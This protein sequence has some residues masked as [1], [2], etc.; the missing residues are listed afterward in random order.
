M[1]FVQ[2][3]YFSKTHGIK[4]QL[5]LRLE[6]N[7]F[8]D[9]AKALLVETATGKAPFFISELKE[10]KVGL[11]IALEDVETI[12]KAKTLLGKKVFIDEKLLA[13]EEE[14]PNLLGFELIDKTHGSLGNIIE[15]SD[16]G[17]QVLVTVHLRNK[18]VILPLVEDFIENM[19]ENTKKIF[20]N[21]PQGLIDLYLNSD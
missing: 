6:K 12:E 4:G 9:E 17:H 2:V 10:N 3:G 20:Y 15:V 1:E 18:E 5:I 14:I 7:F 16:N 8:I 11:I 13:P 19:D 21:A